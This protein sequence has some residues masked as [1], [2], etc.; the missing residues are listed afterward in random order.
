MKRYFLQTLLAATIVAVALPVSA[1]N[2]QKE[3]EDKDGKEKKVQTIVITRNGD[4][5]EK[6]VVEI[7]GDKVT[8]NGKEP[9]KDD[10]VNVNVNVHSYTRPETF[11]RIIARSGAGKNNNWV[12]NDG[13]GPMSLFSEDSNRAMLGIVTDMSDKGAE[14]TSVNKE[15]AA[16][17][18]GLKKGDI[19]TAIGNK[20]IE[21]ADDVHDAVH[22]HKPGDKVA[23]TILRDGKEQK[24][25]A[26]LGKWKGIRIAQMVAPKIE[27]FDFPVPPATY[28]PM[29]GFFDNRPRLGL[30]I[31]DTEDGKGV[32]VTDVEEDGNGAKA[33]I[34]ENDIITHV[35][36]T[37]VN[38]ADEISRIVRDNK[39]KTSIRFKVNRNGKTENIEV[40]IPRKLK[41]AEL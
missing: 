34:K 19:I 40:R 27:N 12:F 26:E 9:G 24:L 20:K 15:S 29:R 35:N 10:N 13:D 3:K 28:A 14:V 32:K 31:Q 33:G 23:I 16:E 39:D 21:S 8:I 5:D 6:T 22:D 4:T 30:S 38:T 17:K 7:K 1:Q 37:E 2:K 25:T 11:S 36:D 41:T 18:A